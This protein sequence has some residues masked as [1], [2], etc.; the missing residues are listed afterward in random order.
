MHLKVAAVGNNGIRMMR[1]IGI[2][3][4]IVV[5]NILPLFLIGVVI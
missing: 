2:G 5:A 4:G 3:I 1:V